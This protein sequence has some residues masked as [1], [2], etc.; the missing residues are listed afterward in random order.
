MTAEVWRQ[1]DAI[2]AEALELA[3]YA[4]A[5]YIE[6]ACQGRPEI[7]AEVKSLLAAGAS[8]GDFLECPTPRM[9]ERVGPYRLLGEVGHGGMSVVYRAE[10]DDGQFR[11]PAAVKLLATGWIGADGMRRFVAERQILASLDHP[12][13]CRLLDGG[14]TEAGVPYLV[15]EFVDGIRLLDYCR[16]EEL[17]ER[18]RLQLFRQICQSVQYAHQNLIVHRDIK[19]GNVL[20]TRQGEAKLMDFGIAKVLA[21]SGERDQ[22]QTAFAAMTPDYASPEQI[23]GQPIT[24]QSDIYSLGVLLYELLTGRRPGKDAPQLSPELMAIVRCA[25]CEDPAGRYAAASALDDDVRRYL[26]GMPVRAVAPSRWYELRKWAARHCR[27]VLAAAAALILILTASAV[28]WRAA[29]VAARERAVAERRFNEVRRLANKVMFEYTQSLGEITAATDVR[30]KMALDAL[31]YLDTV[32]RDKSSDPE[33]LLDLASGYTRLGTVLGAPGSSN[34]GDRPKAL[35]AYGKSRRIHEEVL[36]RYP[37]LRRAPGISFG[38][39]RLEH[40]GQGEFAA[41]G[42]AESRPAARVIPAEPCRLHDPVRV[43]SGQR[44]VGRTGL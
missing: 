3:P 41:S 13:I 2:V 29:V 26:A 42:A 18:E 44:T 35:E 10:R 14:V 30:S 16:Q 23:K 31:Q 8:A 19:P 39:A 15:M 38:F 43:G 37:G 6:H 7:A 5:S 11:K 34:M 4:R 17:G 28:A 27:A 21:A 12:H 40:S 22:T 24:T 25:M 33:L 32:A 1:V 36:R 20:V 9:P